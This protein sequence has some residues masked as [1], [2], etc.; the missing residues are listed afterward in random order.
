MEEDEGLVQSDGG[1]CPTA[2]L[3]HTQEDNDR[4]HGTLPRR[5]SPPPG[6][7]HPH[8]RDTYPHRQLYTYRGG[9]R[10]GGAETMGAQVKR[11]LPDVR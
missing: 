5:T 11:L 3:N 7:E 1:P 2:S 9:Y 10:V 4:A 6:E 8:I